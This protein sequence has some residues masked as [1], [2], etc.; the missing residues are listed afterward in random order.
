MTR[1]QIEVFE[2][3][4]ETLLLRAGSPNKIAFVVKNLID[5]SN[6]CGDDLVKLKKWME[7]TE[8]ANKPVLKARA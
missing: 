3:D 1:K 2:K 6:A 8:A 5:L 4:Y 7:A